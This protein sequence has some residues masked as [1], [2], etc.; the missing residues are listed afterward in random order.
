MKGMEKIEV[1]LKKGLDNKN[2]SERQGLSYIEGHHAIDEANRIFGFD[3][4]SYHLLNL[5]MLKEE[6]VKKGSK[7]AHVVHCVAQVR[8]QVRLGNQ[9][10]CRE[11]VG[12]GSGLSYKGFGDSY[13]LAHKESVTDALKRALR[14]FGNQFGNS[15]YMK[16]NP[17]HKGGKDSKGEVPPEE[18]EKLFTQVREAIGNATTL[19]NLSQVLSTNRELVGGLSTDLRSDLNKIATS[20]KKEL[21]T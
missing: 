17:I 11:D 20:R 10:V 7:E 16:S 15:L 9:V 1:E 2:V 6:K 5:S 18:G 3:G 19:E 8:V 12:Y 21:R 14:S 13:E 4:W